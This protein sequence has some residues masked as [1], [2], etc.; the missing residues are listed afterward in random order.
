MSSVLTGN[1]T[2]TSAAASSTTTTAAQGSEGISLVA[3]LTAMASS[4]TIFGVQMI[5]FMLLKN[6]LARI[7]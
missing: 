7:L 1:A 6:K 3:L 4:A 5:A 2:T